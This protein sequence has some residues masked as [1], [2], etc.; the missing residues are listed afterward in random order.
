MRILI[1]DDNVS[2][3]KR[4]CE[5][6]QEY[7][8][9]YEICGVASNSASGIAIFK[10]KKPDV[11]FLDVEL[12]D[13]NGFD[14]LKEQIRPFLHKCKIVIYTAYNEYLKPTVRSDAF[15][16]LLKPIDPDDFVEVMERLEKSDVC[17][18]TT[19]DDIFEN[20]SLKHLLPPKTSFLNVNINDVCFFQYKSLR[21][22]WEAITERQAP[23]ELK[24]GVKAEDLLLLGEQFQQAAK[25]YI[26]NSY[27]LRDIIN[28]KCYF[29]P[30]FDHITNV[31]VGRNYMK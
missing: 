23:I 13:I 6:L 24:Q 16:I 27:Y 29:F 10:E 18:D 31:K 17:T 15:D 9:D 14:L 4:L 7:N 26:I 5:K 19:N 11:V 25:G 2:D 28:R 1:I 21:R 22:R 12:P 8:P 30:P 3:Q 20:E